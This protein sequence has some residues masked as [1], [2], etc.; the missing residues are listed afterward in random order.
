[1]GTS[2][3]KDCSD[4]VVWSFVILLTRD[5]VLLEALTEGALDIFS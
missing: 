1:M 2:S 3:A 5:S 4:T